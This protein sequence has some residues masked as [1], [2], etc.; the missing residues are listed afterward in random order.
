[1]LILIL[2]KFVRKEWNKEEKQAVHNALENY[3]RRGVVPGKNDCERCKA[4]AGGAL[5]GR[6]W[7]SIK[8]YIK[9]QIDKREKIKR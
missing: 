5:D 9:N 4:E 1:M 3:I 2:E 6:E 8:Y 7:R